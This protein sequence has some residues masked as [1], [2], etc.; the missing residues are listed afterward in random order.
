MPSIPASRMPRGDPIVEWGYRGCR[1][2]WSSARNSAT[3]GPPPRSSSYRFS[4]DESDASAPHTLF[5]QSASRGSIRICTVPDLCRT[6]GGAH[7]PANKER[8]STEDSETAPTLRSDNS[9]RP[10][11][12][13]RSDSLAIGCG[14]EPRSAH[15]VDCQ[16]V[17]PN[18]LSNDA[19]TRC[20]IV[21]SG[22]ANP[23]SYQ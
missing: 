21:S 7:V 17:R 16:S 14:F 6:N 13:Q 22:V 8:R 18:P 9:A 10:R 12:E 19:A 4:H 20:M 5:G 1:K 3:T 11:G 2:D 15:W 23:P